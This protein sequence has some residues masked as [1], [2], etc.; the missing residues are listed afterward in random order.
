MAAMRA[1]DLGR[2]RLVARP[3]SRRSPERLLT[4]ENFGQEPAPMRRSQLC[5]GANPRPRNSSYVEAR[6]GTA[7][8]LHS[9]RCFV[10]SCGTLPAAGASTLALRTNV[11]TRQLV[12]LDASRSSLILAF[13]QARRTCECDSTMYRCPWQRSASVIAGYTSSP[14]VHENYAKVLSIASGLSPRHSLSA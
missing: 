6:Q 4:G 5:T 11:V 1:C 3:E 10:S 7:T 8:S 2:Q 13:A 9:F 14:R 12:N